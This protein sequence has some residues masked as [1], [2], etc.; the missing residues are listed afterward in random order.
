MPRRHPPTPSV[1][2]PY[3][4]VVVVVVGGGGGGGGGVQLIPL[5][6]NKVCKHAF[7]SHIIFVPNIGVMPTPTINRFACVTLNF[8][9]DKMFNTVKI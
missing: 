2:W 6:N 5:L 8:D 1:D 3:Y 9:P 7:T 4:F